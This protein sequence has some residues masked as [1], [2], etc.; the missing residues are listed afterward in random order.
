M[1]KIFFYGGNIAEAIIALILYS[2]L[3]VFYFDV[4]SVH[5]KFH[6]TLQIQVFVT[7]LI[8]VIVLYL[9]FWLYKRQLKEVNYWDFNE[10]P[11]WD[12]KRIGIAILGF[13]I[14]IISQII[15]FKIVGGTNTQ[16]KNQQELK[17]LAKQSGK[18]F[19]LLVFFFGPFCEEIIFRGMFFNTF[20]TK[21]T[22]ANKWIG[23]IVSGFLFAYVHDS[24][25]SKFIFVYWAM[26][27]ILGWVYLE[28]KD[29]RYS[30]IAH[31]LNNA[32]SLI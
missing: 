10:E 9:L 7:A 29:L 26:G 11:H 30:M 16:P 24:S 17:E 3:Q 14:L 2:V 13:V 22:K 15:I 31:M 25:F 28:T 21:K 4:K 27:C 32:M 12:K 23:I 18:M 5:Q 19:N 1:K 6:F 20:C 8:T